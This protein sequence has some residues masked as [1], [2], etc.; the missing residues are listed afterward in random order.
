MGRHQNL[1]WFALKYAGDQ[2]PDVLS[3]FL[4]ACLSNALSTCFVLRPFATKF[5][6]RFTCY[7]A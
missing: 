3:K 1:D 5:V 6:E 4:T 7:L 2:F